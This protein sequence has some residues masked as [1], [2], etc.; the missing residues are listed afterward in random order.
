MSLSEIN[1]F[2]TAQKKLFCISRNRHHSERR[3]IWRWVDLGRQPRSGWFSSALHLPDKQKIVSSR[4]LFTILSALVVKIRSL[5][6]RDFHWNRRLNGA[7]VCRPFRSQQPCPGCSGK[8]PPPQHSFPF[9]IR[10]CLRVH[11]ISA[12]ASAPNF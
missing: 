4:V 6:K 1:F 7:L 11:N 5:K 3:E 10:A 2:C 12:T 8:L 9:H